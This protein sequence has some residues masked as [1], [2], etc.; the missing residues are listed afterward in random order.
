MASETRSTAL[1]T[2]KIISSRSDG[3]LRKGG[4]LLSATQLLQGAT[5]VHPAPR[6][7]VPTAVSTISSTRNHVMI[8]NEIGRSASQRS[9]GLGDCGDSRDDHSKASPTKMVGS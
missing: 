3:R 2:P 4:L 6:K 1:T 8:Q 9:K 7:N 5:Q